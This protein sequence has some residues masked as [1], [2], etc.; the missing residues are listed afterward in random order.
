MKEQNKVTI[1]GGGLAG[2]EA[3]YQLAQRGHQVVLFEM[4]PRVTNDVHLGA[5][6]A[7]LVCSNSFRSDDACHPAGLLKREMEVLGSLIMKC[8]RG[9]AVLAGGA[10]AVDR[11]LFSEAVTSEIENH[12]LIE[13]VRREVTAIPDEPAIIAAG[14]LCSKRLAEPLF[15]QLGHESL[16]FYDAIAPVIELDSLDLDV[17]FYQSRY[18]KGTGSDYLNIPLS[19]E[20]YIQ[21]H[22]ELTQAERV[23]Q[24]KHEKLKFFE[25]CLPIEEMAD[26]G[27]DT[28]RFGPMKPVGLTNPHTGETPYAVIQLRQDDMAKTLWNMVGF[29]TRMKWGEQKRLFRSLPGMARA[30]FTRYGMIHRNTYINSPLYLDETFKVKGSHALYVAGQISG[31]EGYLE[32]AASG[33][34]AA[35]H[36]HRQLSNHKSIPFPE[37][38]A[39][40]SLARYISFKEHRN[41]QPTNVNFG[42]FP[43]L[44]KRMPKKMRR[45]HYVERSWRSFEAF[46][47][48][49]EEEPSSTIPWPFD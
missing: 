19:Q 31:V 20:E 8:A 34:M 39:M 27:R 36:L 25:G 22:T 4:R 10:L 28:L 16:Y 44:E 11:N 18:D 24:K 26:R 37:E 12:N 29:Q 35:L 48:K 23:E 30:R 9:T 6:L 38:T 40:G 33:L 45:K 42:I 2:S 13:L 3:A 41:F 32:S 21:F 49:I 15:H 14:P 47:H 43:D 5:G 1:V 46:L 7:E 17:L